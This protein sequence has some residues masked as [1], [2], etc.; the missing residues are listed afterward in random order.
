M[1]RVRKMPAKAPTNAA[2][3]NV[4]F[5]AILPRREPLFLWGRAYVA[6]RVDFLWFDV[7]HSIDRGLIGVVGIFLKGPLLLNLGLLFVAHACRRRSMLSAG[8][9]RLHEQDSRRN[10]NGEER[11]GGSRRQG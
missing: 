5:S 3:T 7:L 6:P 10:R 8:V 9:R 2:I 11:D 1:Y 4:V